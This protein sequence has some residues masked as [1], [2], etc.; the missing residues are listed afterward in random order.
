MQ[1]KFHDQRLKKCNLEKSIEIF[2]YTIS[3]PCFEINPDIG[4]IWNKAVSAMIVMWV[5]V[6]VCVP[7]CMHASTHKYQTV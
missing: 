1:K 2:I 4:E 5:S 7:A 6:Y 3:Q